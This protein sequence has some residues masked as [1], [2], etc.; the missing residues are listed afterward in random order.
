MEATPR[1]TPLCR[2]DHRSDDPQRFE[3]LLSAID[4][5]AH[6]AVA[7]LSVIRRFGHTGRFYLPNRI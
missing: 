4:A 3:L 1:S 2:Y 5:I 7:D 6:I